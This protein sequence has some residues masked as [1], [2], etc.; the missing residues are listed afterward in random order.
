LPPPSEPPSTGDPPPP[1]DPPPGDPPPGDPEPPPESCGAQTTQRARRISLG[2]YE[3]AVIRLF[4]VNVGVANNFAPEP[5]SHGF[6]NQS[7]KLAISRGNFEEFA[8]AAEIA[9]EGADVAARAP[10]APGALPENCAAEFVTAFAR[11]AYGRNLAEAEL[12]DLSMLYQQGALLDGYERGIR[13]VMEAILLSP[14]F[15]YREEIGA[16]RPGGAAVLSAD[17]VANAVA[18]ALTGLRPDAQLLARAA[19]D[20]AFRSPSVL[21]EE[22]TR[23]VA[24]PE[25]RRHLARFLRGWL[26]VPDIRAV[27]KIPAMFPRF[28]PG[29]KADLDTELDLFLEYVLGE[30][31]GTLEAL[32]GS[33]VTFASAP[34][35]AT[36]Y[37]GDYRAPLVPPVT[38]APGEFAK[39]E[40]NTKIRKGV[41]S[42]GGWLAA[43]AP[44]HRSSPVD[45]GLAIRT[46]FFCQRIDSPPPGA[47]ATA[48]GSG[49]GTATTRQKFE[50]H[51]NNAVCQ[52]CHKLMDPIGFG[53]EMMDALG[54]YRDT[55]G[56]L[57]VDSSGKLTDTDVDGPFQGPAELADKLL[58]SPQ[59]RACFVVQMYR[60]IEGRDEVA[61]DSCAISRLQGFFAQ[62]KTSIGELATEMV[63]DPRFVYRSIQP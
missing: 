33:T 56:G 5:T 26:G 2:E 63:S 62:E 42:L 46:R 44:V 3:R 24:T 48:P 1:G 7:D 27:N 6:D 21:R 19:L 25:A 45:R 16:A 37:A 55:E 29:L 52:S 17:E 28:T 10:C 53:M 57:P 59:V 36:I 18:F 39:I 13:T 61:E 38:P 11:Q 23:L 43:H 30:Q 12:A 51:A 4:D 15:L 14:H 32:L 49:D 60:Y 34:V 8:A 50:A 40:L 41:L 9:A 58:A 35:L 47:V 31:G 22:A 20:P 54:A